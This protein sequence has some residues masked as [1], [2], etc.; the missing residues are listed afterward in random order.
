MHSVFA[1]TL[2]E[3]KVANILHEYLDPQ[4]KTKFGDAQK[5]YADLCNFYE[6]GAMTCVSA[7]MLESRLTNMWLNI[8]WTKTVS[9][10][11]ITVLHLIWDH[12]EVTQGIHAD[13]HCIK[14]LNATFFEHKDMAAHIQTVETQD[15]MLLR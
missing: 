8:T 4:D 9:T 5:I 15:G 14:K 1:K 10:F 2:V 3:G 6:G 7:A 13:N 12:K 11:L